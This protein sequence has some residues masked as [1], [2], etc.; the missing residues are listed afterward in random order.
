[1]RVWERGVGET[2][3]CGTGACAVAVASH[4]RG[5]T[6]PRVAVHLPGGTLD[7]EVAGDT[8]YM[9]GPAEES[10]EGVLGAHLTSLLPRHERL[11]S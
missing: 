5:L 2:L 9:T 7:I 3:A 11:P 10:F 4:A 8:V 1:M 6:G